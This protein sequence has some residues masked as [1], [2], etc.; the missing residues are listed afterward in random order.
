MEQP[1]KKNFVSKMLKTLCNAAVGLCV[2]CMCLFKWFE[3]IRKRR[4]DLE[5]ELSVGHSSPAWDPEMLENFVNL[6]PETIEWP[7]NWWRTN[8]TLTGSL[9]VLLF[10]NI[11]GRQWA[12]CSWSTYSQGLANG[13]QSQS[14]GRPHCSMV[15]ISDHVSHLTSHQLF[16]SPMWK[17]ALREEEVRTRSWRRACPLN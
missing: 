8:C 16:Y 2:C 1:V 17:A 9:L 11:L 13:A 3:R 7:Y 10:V 14:F 5:D 15:E 6:Q 12:A 4:Y